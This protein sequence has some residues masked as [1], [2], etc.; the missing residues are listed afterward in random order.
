MKFDRF[1]MIQPLYVIVHEA[2]INDSEDPV[3]AARALEE[4]ARIRVEEDFVELAD[5]DI[6]EIPYTLQDRRRPLRVCGAFL[7]ICVPLHTL[8]L[9]EAGYDAEVYEEASVH[10]WAAEA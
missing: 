2:Q 3:D 1:S 9:L 8:A 5:G 10:L 6:M 4:L 7:E